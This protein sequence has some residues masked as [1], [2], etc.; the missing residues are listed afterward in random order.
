MK[1]T[2]L[3]LGAGASKAF[4]PV[5]PTGSELFRNIN[6][7]F[8]TELSL[9]DD[10]LQHKAGPYLSAMMNTM[11]EA[12]GPIDLGL[13]RKI[14]SKI[15]KPQLGNEWKVMRN[16][17]TDPLSIDRFLAEVLKNDPDHAKATRILKFAVGYIIKGAEQAV[18]E[19]ATVNEGNWIQILSDKIASIDIAEIKQCV[20]VFNFNYDRSFEYYLTR[21][22]RGRIELPV[23]FLSGAHHH[24]YGSL[25]PLVEVPFDMANNHRSITMTYS[26][27]I[28]L[29]GEERVVQLLSVKDFDAVHFIGFGY[30]DENLRLLG[31]PSSASARLSG[32][33]QGVLPERRGAL[34]TD[35][36]IETVDATCSDYC[37]QISFH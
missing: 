28:K 19:G 9:R 29:I 14:K 15:W 31:L 16:I 17:T 6:H 34:A 26:K 21:Y 1:K 11:V 27:G 32:T 37:R 8:I 25:G 10:I 24:V 12:L 3:V 23:D 20:Q 22:L 35:Y 36:G 33:G 4:S 2:L 18:Q 30:N 13:L 5:F 7:H